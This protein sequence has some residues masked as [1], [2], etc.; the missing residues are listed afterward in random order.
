MVAGYHFQKI[1]AIFTHSLLTLAHF[2][3]EREIRLNKHDSQNRPNSSKL[4]FARKKSTTAKVTIA[5][6]FASMEH[7]AAYRQI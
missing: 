6:Q 5:C 1:C 4:N 2:Y 7:F 3:Q